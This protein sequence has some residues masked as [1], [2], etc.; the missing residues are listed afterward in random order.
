MVVEIGGRLQL[1]P[2][3]TLLTTASL[4]LLEVGAGSKRA[5]RWA[6][7]CIGLGMLT[8]GPIALLVVALVLLTWKLMPGARR[9]GEGRGIH[10]DWAAA[11]LILLPV[12]LWALLAILA[13]PDLARPLLFDQHVGRVAS[14]GSGTHWGPPQKT[15]LGLLPL[16]LP[17]TFVL[18]AGW[19][20]GF[21]AARGGGDRSDVGMARAWG[22]GLVLLVFFSAIPPK[23]DLY[24]L[25]AYPAFALVT[26]R[27]WCRVALTEAPGRGRKVLLA[28]GPALLLLVGGALT[29][30]G[31][32]GGVIDSLGKTVS[33]GLEDL[34]ELADS[35]IWRLPL[36]ALPLVVGSAAALVALFQGRVS[37]MGQRTL[38]GFAAGS[39]LIFALFFPPI[40]QSK[41]AEALAVELSDHYA[42]RTP[43]AVPVIGIKPEGLRFYSDVP[44]VGRRYPHALED[45][46]TGS[47]S[48]FSEEE[49]APEAIL[50]A[51]LGA[52][53][54]RMLAVLSEDLWEGL[55]SEE[56]AKYQ[57]LSES[58]LG[59][60]RVVILTAQ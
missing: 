58:R 19:V 53:G 21:G 24:L 50:E 12:A 55:A 37:E 17:W 44:A 38:I 11:G 3:L 9:E 18:I 42:P 27:W 60:R 13:E 25:P 28:V 8:K 45:Q 15:I 40:D 23:R 32:F 5:A 41:S 14:K 57:V 43:E 7:L 48:A 10:W 34:P 1:D 52:E 31:L 22:W 46:M 33:E 49:L 39:S 20:R 6:A 36:G 35:L 30:V 26:A 2:L 47:E 16:F 56:R 54:E 4:Y 59:R 29:F 51:W